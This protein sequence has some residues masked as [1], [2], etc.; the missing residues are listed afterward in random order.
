MPLRYI[1]AHFA[2]SHVRYIQPLGIIYV[3]VCK[4]AFQNSQRPGVAKE[5][6]ENT[7]AGLL[8]IIFVF[9]SDHI[10]TFS[11]SAVIRICY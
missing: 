5:G 1:D 4:G 9:V 2:L 3:I 7:I 10:A 8:E 11:S 6:I